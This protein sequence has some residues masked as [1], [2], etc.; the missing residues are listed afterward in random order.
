[1]APWLVLAE[2]GPPP[3][4]RPSPR[5][6]STATDAI[7]PAVPRPT[8]GALGDAHA[9]QHLQQ[10]VRRQPVGARGQSARHLDHRLRDAAGPIPGPPPSMAGP[11]VRGRTSTGAH[12]SH[13]TDSVEPWL[14][15]IRHDA[16]VL[17]GV[18]ATTA[19]G[20]DPH[21][22]IGAV[23]HHRR[24]LGP[25][26][27]RSFV[28]GGCARRLG[29]A[30]ERASPTGPRRSRRSTVPGWT[31]RMRRL[32]GRIRRRCQSGDEPS[33]RARVSRRMHVRP[34]PPPPSPSLSLFLS[35]SFS[36]SLSGSIDELNVIDLGSTPWLTTRRRTCPICKGDVVRSLAN[37]SPA[38]SDR[39]QDD[40]EPDELGPL[41]LPSF[42]SRERHAHD[43]IH[44]DLE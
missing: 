7:D 9:D 19:D 11:Q 5:Q 23:S 21:P 1:M 13:P 37:E 22:I 8:C 33:V 26:E 20:G 2:S 42:P 35:L 6:A 28:A 17:G 38:S 10:P 14:G 3:C 29:G 24:R 36:L 4:A 43:E 18:S 16:L 41:P 40:P 44:P 15:A 12:L 39:Y 27:H 30:V 32:L 34:I 31:G 25:D